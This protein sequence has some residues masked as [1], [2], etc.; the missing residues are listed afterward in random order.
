MKG[1][2]I[3]SLQLQL[4]HWPDGTFLTRWWWWRRR[5]RHGRRRHS[6]LLW[7]GWGWH[8]HRWCWHTSGRRWR[9]YHANRRGHHIWWW[10]PHWEPV[11]HLGWHGGRHRL[12]SG[13]SRLPVHLHWRGELSNRW[14]RWLSNVLHLSR[15]CA[16]AIRPWHRWTTIWKT[17]GW[18]TTCKHCVWPI[19][20]R[21]WI[22]CC[23]QPLCQW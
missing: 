1:A 2:S 20:L 12:L 21:S 15:N 6:T 23:Q 11:L 10:W 8:P 22:V 5:H 13:P 16:I 3:L 7:R 19:L 9:P 14:W 17:L 18:R 4:A